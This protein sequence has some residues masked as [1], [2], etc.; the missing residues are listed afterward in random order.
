MN[1]K[2]KRINPLVADRIAKGE[3]PYTVDPT[4]GVGVTTAIAHGLISKAMLEP[5]IEVRPGVSSD[6]GIEESRVCSVALETAHKLGLRHIFG[7]PK[8][9]GP[10]G[11]SNVVRPKYRAI[12]FEYRPGNEAA[13]DEETYL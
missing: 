6:D 4:K 10:T 2:S 3:S 5:N 13:S 11:P 12:I 7:V 9:G 1:A 8:S